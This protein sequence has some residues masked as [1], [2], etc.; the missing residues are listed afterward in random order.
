MIKSF[1]QFIATIFTFCLFSW[2]HLNSPN[3]AFYDPQQGPNHNFETHWYYEPRNS[4]VFITVITFTLTWF[5]YLS[6][7]LPIQKWADWLGWKTD[8][9]SFFILRDKKGTE[10]SHPG[11]RTVF[12]MLSSFLNTGNTRGSDISDLDNKSLIYWKIMKI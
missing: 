7:S 8:V 6:L 10:R 4:T 9:L 3:L 2:G 12:A 5:K 1:I 11:V